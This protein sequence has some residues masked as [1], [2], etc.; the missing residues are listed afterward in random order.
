MHLARE[1]HKAIIPIINFTLEVLFVEG[2]LKN[3][4]NSGQQKNC[5]TAVIMYKSES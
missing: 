4:R 5:V 3:L 1:Q 2:H